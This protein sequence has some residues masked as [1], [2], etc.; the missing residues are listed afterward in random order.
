MW[1]QAG[2][3]ST[4]LWGKGQPGKKNDCVGRRKVDR[5]SLQSLFCW[6]TELLDHILFFLYTQ[7]F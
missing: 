2:G 3:D 7:V 5:K 4:K 1:R 6:H